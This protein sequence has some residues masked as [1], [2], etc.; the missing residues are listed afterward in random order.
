V[1]LQMSDL[2]PPRI[3]PHMVADERA[4]LEEWLDY[5]GQLFSANA[6][7]LTMSSFAGPPARRR[8]SP[9]LAWCAT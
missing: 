9:C 2:A 8:T 5:H 4:M 1:V 3:Q 7:G 6:P